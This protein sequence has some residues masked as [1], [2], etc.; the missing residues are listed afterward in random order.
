MTIFVSA[1]HHP[2]VK[3]ARFKDEFVEYDEAVPGQDLICNTLK[4]FGIRVQTGTLRQKVK[5]INNLIE[6]G[7]PTIDTPI[8]IEIHFNSAKNA[9]GRHIGTGTETLYRGHEGEIIANVVQEA[10]CKA[11]GTKSRGVKERNDLHF[12]KATIC[13]AIIIEPEFVHR[14]PI[15]QHYRKSACLRIAQALFRAQGYLKIIRADT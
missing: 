1:G 15:I 6:L 9:K 5:R 10:M 7:G 4:S 8:A 3:G 13:P 11:M 14:Y 2:K 12:L